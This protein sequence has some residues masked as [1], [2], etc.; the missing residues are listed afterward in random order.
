[1]MENMGRKIRDTE[2]YRE[3]RKNEPTYTNAQKEE[4]PEKEG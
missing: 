2:K 1:M 3:D 4:Y